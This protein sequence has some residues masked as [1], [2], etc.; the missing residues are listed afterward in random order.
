MTADAAVLSPTT[1]SSSAVVAAAAR[2]GLLRPHGKKQLPPWLFYDDEGSLLF[3]EITRL[4][5]YYLTRAERSIFQAHADA[6]IAAAARGA[7]DALKVV[8]LGAGTALKSQILL[9]AVVRR[10]GRCL[11]VPIDVSAAALDLARE[12]LV[13]QEP[14]V[15][16]RALAMHNEEA[17]AEVRA[18]GPRRL[19]LFIGSSIGN[20]NDDDAVVL[21]RQIKDSLLPGGALLLGT[22]R[23]KD[24]AKILA[25][26]DDDEGV[27]ARFNLRALHHLNEVLGADFNVD[28]FVHRAVWN[29][30]RSRVEMHLQ[31]VGAQRVTLGVGPRGGADVV[32]DFA[33][34]ER[35]HTESSHKYSEEKV[36]SLLA[37][38]GFTLEQ[39]WM[40]SDELFA[41]HLGRA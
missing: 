33:D 39:T 24:P 12:R 5:A 16:V 7:T 21:L 26:Y 28:R 4:D 23:L 19:V 37:R 36:A 11:F 2:D 15:E 9:S 31:S 10:Q 1:A 3:E 6:I 18:L 8:E 38:A 41:V 25:A 20:L 14:L 13:E 27:T 29:A 34:G 40:D 30:E 22:D 32:V 17:F 35:I